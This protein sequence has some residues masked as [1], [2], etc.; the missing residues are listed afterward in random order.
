MYN[1]RGISL[2]AEERLAFQEGFRSM[3][4]DGQISQLSV[5]PRWVIVSQI[6]S[7]SLTTKLHLSSA[8]AILSVNNSCILYGRPV[9]ADGARGGA[10]C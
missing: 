5:V 3:E 4:L 6:L 2:L 8:D 7:S 1:M 9:Y 10:V